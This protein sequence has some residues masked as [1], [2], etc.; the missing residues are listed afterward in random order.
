MKATRVNIGGRKTRRL[1]VAWNEPVWACK[2]KTPPIIFKDFTPNGTDMPLS[3]KMSELGINVNMTIGDFIVVTGKRLSLVQSTISLALS[4]KEHVIFKMTV[5][6]V[7][8]IY[9]SFNAFRFLRIYSFLFC[10]Y[11]LN[12][13]ILNTLEII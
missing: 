11:R 8:I 13:D 6:Y 2:P 7:Q 5:R 1:F 10:W 9:K 3:F 12:L 4:G